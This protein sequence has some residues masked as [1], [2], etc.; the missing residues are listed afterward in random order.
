MEAACLQ[1][2]R[3]GY[4]VSHWIKV[5]KLTFNEQ[6]DAFTEELFDTEKDFIQTE[7]MCFNINDRSFFQ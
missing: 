1:K 5:F 6:L 4:L 2:K 3:T 7:I